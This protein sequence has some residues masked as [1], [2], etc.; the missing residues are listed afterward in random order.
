MAITT[1][2]LHGMVHQCY[3]QIEY[4]GVSPRAVKGLLLDLTDFFWSKKRTS[5]SL[6]AEHRP[7]IKLRQKQYHYQ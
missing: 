1:H 3:R 5:P 2:T 6:P 7:L 4:V